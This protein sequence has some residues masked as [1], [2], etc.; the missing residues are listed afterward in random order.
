MAGATRLLAHVTP[1]PRAARL[2]E[3]LLGDVWVVDSLDS[4]SG[5]FRGVAV[6]RSGRLLD[7]ATGELS[8]AAA[9]G[10]ERLLEELGRRDRAR[11]GLGGRGRPRRSEAR[12][13]VG[14][15]AE[16]VV[17]ADAAR[18]EAEATLRR[19]ARDHAEASDEAERAKWLLERRSESADEGPDG[20]RRAGLIADLRAERR[21]AERAER[22]RTERAN[23]LVALRTG[24]EADADLTRAAERVALA[25]E[26]ALTAVEARRDVLTAELEAGAAAGD[27]T[28]AALRACAHEEADLQGRLRRASE[29]VTESEVTA[30]Q[31]RDASADVERELVELA[32]RL[33]LEPEPAAEPLPD[34]ERAA[35]EARVVRLRARREQLGPVNP[36]AGQEYE[37]AVTH[38]EE[39][40]AQRRD[41]ESALAELEG[42]IKETDRR[43]KESFEETF[44]AAA[45]N[46]ED[47]VE[48]L[49]PGGRGA[50]RLVRADQVPA[51][52]GRR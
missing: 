1:E 12:E 37:E 17:G 33:G 48:H 5:S 30:Q 42:L 41:L 15:A 34:E 52:G 11:G 10:G 19:A 20:I 40:E 51:L 26:A 3:R 24:I 16:A 9:G 13:A 18:E 14:V 25:L 8:Q 39:L 45:R 2:A 32:G 22:E 47:V 36:L 29:A 28:A 49:F 44:T 43:I 21:M 31:T 38:V 7:A 23:A 50:L 6:T 35:L 27:Q 4:V 46:F